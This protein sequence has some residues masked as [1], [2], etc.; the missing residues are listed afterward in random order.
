[1]Y[2]NLNLNLIGEISIASMTLPKI[3]LM[4]K[5]QKTT[6]YFYLVPMPQTILAQLYP[7]QTTQYLK[8]IYM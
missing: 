2:F 5:N 4:I 1:M 8:Q 3:L 7:E 6:C